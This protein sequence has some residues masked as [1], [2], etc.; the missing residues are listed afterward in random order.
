MSL[1]LENYPMFGNMYRSYAPYCFIEL[2]AYL[3]F[4][5][6]RNKSQKLS[7]HGGK[8]NM[9]PCIRSSVGP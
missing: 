6:A 9:R 1:Y 2:L 7:W 8:V 3:N 4:S 5:L